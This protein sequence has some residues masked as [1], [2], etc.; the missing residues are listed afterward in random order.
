MPDL[1]FFGRLDFAH[2]AALNLDANF[3]HDITQTLL[4][5]ARG[6]TDDATTVFKK[7]H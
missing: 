1:A 7:P 4:K 5:L 2:L 3:K 6:G